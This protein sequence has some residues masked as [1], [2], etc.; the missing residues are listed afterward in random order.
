VFFRQT[1]ALFSIQGAQHEPEFHPYRFLRPNLPCRGPRRHWGLHPGSLG[2]E[3]QQTVPPC[4]GVC[5][6]QCGPGLLR[7]VSED[8]NATL[9][10]HLVRCVHDALFYGRE[11]VLLQRGHASASVPVRPGRHRLRRR[12]EVL[13]AG[14]MSELVS[15]DKPSP[16]IHQ[17]GG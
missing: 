10:I 16:I 7:S 3:E 11:Q 5:P 4:R 2:Q 6:L 14:G 13:H 12:H 1:T 17:R 9:G 8:G 15:N